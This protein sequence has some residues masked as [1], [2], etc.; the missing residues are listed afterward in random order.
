MHLTATFSTSIAFLAAVAS[1]TPIEEGFIGRATLASSPTPTPTPAGFNLTNVET[2]QPSGVNGDNTY[3][4]A[5]HIADLAGETDC[6]ISWPITAP[7]DAEKL[8]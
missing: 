4:V 5:F 1:T 7:V 6:S 8:V 3:T 2:H